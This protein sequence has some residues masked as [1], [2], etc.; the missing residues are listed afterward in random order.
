MFRI[1]NYLKKREFTS[2]QIAI[3]RKFRVHF[4][5]ENFGEYN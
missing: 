4:I 5:P 2:K 3:Q 1:R